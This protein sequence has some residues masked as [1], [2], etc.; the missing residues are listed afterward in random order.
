MA[1]LLVTASA[2]M[3]AI[4]A[5][6]VPPA[7]AL[8]KEVRDTYNQP[9]DRQYAD[10]CGAEDEHQL[11]FDGPS[12]LWPPNHKYYAGQVAVTAVDTDSSDGDGIDLTSSGTHNQYEGDTEW[13]GSGN[14]GDDIKSDGEDTDASVASVVTMESGNGSVAIEWFVRSERSGQKSEA[15]GEGRVY[16]ITG[17]AVFADDGSSC[18]GSWEI[19]VPHDMS[20][21]NR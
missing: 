4:A 8:P 19:V 12:R 20:P 16:E 13:T 14:T 15:L 10:E 17:N 11:Y 1:K 9:G 2:I 6:I 18:S 7:G 3:M 5:T 21:K